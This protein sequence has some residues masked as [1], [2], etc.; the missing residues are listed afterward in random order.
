M[1]TTPVITVLSLALAP[2]AAAQPSP[3]VAAL[4][5]AVRPALPF[6]PADDSGTVPEGRSEA[7]RWFV[8]WPQAP[9]ETQIVARANP[10]HP[11]TQKTVAAAEAVIQRAVA[12]AE[13]KAQ[14]AYDR[15]L[16]ELKRTGKSA[17]LDGISLD[18]EGAAGQQLDAEL[19]LT[20]ALVDAAPFE[21]ASGVEPEVSSG[22]AGVTWQVTVPPNTYSETAA[23][24]RR[25]RFAA[26]EVRL[27]I[28]PAARPSVSRRGDR[29]F[30]IAPPAGAAMVVLRGNDTL[31]KQVLAGADWTRLHGR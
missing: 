9:D 2:L 14:A 23:G 17:D 28:G 4:V 1:R 24:E 15:A 27:L 29:R 6:P 31:L 25:D 20:I 21:I 22:P 10:L 11:D 13:R 8:I 7:S 5:E 18:D 30:A 12:A 16:D 3:Q 19:E 26:S